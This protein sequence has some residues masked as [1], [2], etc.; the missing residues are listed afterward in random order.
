M[1]AFEVWETAIF[2]H[3]PFGAHQSH[4]HLK[5]LIQSYFHRDFSKEPNREKHGR[6]QKQGEIV[7]EASHPSFHCC[8][9]FEKQSEKKRS[10]LSF[11]TLSCSWSCSVLGGAAE[12]RV[13][14]QSW[15]WMRTFTWQ[16]F[17]IVQ[18]AQPTNP[19][20]QTPIITLISTFFQVKLAFSPTM[21]L[22]Q[23]YRFLF[24]TLLLPI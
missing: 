23:K 14:N 19:T 18:Q 15:H 17:I 12:Q 11:S 2:R 3:R 6:L 7:N 1:P 9:M 8:H 24:W 20:E 5:H 21:P 13:K 22:T 16:W 4:Q 10:F